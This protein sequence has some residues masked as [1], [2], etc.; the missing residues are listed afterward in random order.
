MFVN[1]KLCI[2]K[3]KPQNYDFRPLH[4]IEAIWKAYI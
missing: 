1:I 4:V 2:N 3:N